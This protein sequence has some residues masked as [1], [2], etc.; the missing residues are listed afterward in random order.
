MAVRPP[1]RKVAVAERT[2]GIERARDA[3]QQEAWAEAYGELSTTD[4]SDLTPQDLEAL[5]DAAWWLSKND[6]S[7]AARQQ[8]Y[9][10][11]GAAHDERRAAYTPGA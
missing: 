8:A 2:A 10:A 1:P 3:V 6:E 5:A 11:F 9:A 4:P 7:I